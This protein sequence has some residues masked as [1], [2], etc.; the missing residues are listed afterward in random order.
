MQERIDSIVSM[1]PDQE[2]RIETLFKNDADFRE[3]CIDFMMCASRLLDLKKDHFL[4]HEQIAE[5][6]EMQ[7]DLEQDILR[8][9]IIRGPA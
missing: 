6:E 1:F 3:I 4:N 5:Y 7:R 2:G 8:M 9:I